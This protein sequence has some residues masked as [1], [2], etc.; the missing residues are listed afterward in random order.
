MALRRALLVCLDDL[1]AVVR[2]FLNPNLSRSGLDGCLRRHG[3][4][5]NGMVKRFNGRIE[6]MLQSHHFRSGEDLEATLHRYLCSII[7]N[8][9][10][11]P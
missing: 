1:L 9:R 11:Q 8:C 7:S 6:E 5:T 3:V 2:K 4:G 10:N